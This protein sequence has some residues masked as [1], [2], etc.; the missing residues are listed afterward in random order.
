MPVSEFDKKKNTL[1]LNSTLS[2][3]L[4]ATAFGG[5]NSGLLS[6]NNRMDNGDSHFLASKNY[7]RANNNVTELKGRSSLAATN[8]GFTFFQPGG[9]EATLVSTEKLI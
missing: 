2:P 4:A 3:K 7:M 9:V 1:D 5:V 6:A 8:K